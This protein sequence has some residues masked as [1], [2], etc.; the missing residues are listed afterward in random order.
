MEPID[1]VSGNEIPP[2]SLPQEVRDD[3]DAKLSSGEYV[4][5]ADVV[6][7]FG[8]DYIEKL[9]TKAKTGLEELQANGRI[10]GKSEEDLPFSPEELDAHEAEMATEA[11]TEP[12][13]MATGGYVS[14]QMG[15]TDETT[16]GPINPATG[17]PWWMSGT[18]VTKPA[19]TSGVLARSSNDREPSQPL[20]GL[21]GNPD[22]WSTKDFMNYTKNRGSGVNKI[23]EAG[24]SSFIPLGKLGLQHR[25]NYLNKTVPGQLEKMISTGMTTKGEKLSPED[26]V[27][28]KASLEKI[29]TEGD[30]TPGLVK[31]GGRLG[32][33]LKSVV[34]KLFPRTEKKEAISTRAKSAP[35]PVTKTTSTSRPK[36]KPEIKSASGGFIDRRPR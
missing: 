2:G 27:S 30:Y 29:K 32:E 31:S 3:V 18:P 15:V 5:P 7:Y 20:T 12:V 14:P 28:L 13:T 25:H 16:Q 10:G 22:Q 36:P 19:T 11:P 6:R 23:I 4:L 1:P 26:V 33:G 9:V 35:K 24:I 21:A 8:L 34:E 17:L